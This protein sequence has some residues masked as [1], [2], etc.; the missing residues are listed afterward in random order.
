M[1]SPQPDDAHRV[2]QINDTGELLDSVEQEISLLDCCLV[3]RILRIW[4]V[5][6]QDTSNLVDFTVKL[7]S[8]YE[9]R[10]LPGQKYKQLL[11]LTLWAT[12]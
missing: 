5:R 10:Q 7:S 2:L 1:S 6:L 11:R 9:K 3:E 12:R 4:P 8:S